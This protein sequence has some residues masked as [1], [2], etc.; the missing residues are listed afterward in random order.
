MKRA[1]LF[2][3]GGFGVALLASPLVMLAV[4]RT[5]PGDDPTLQAPTFHFWVVSMTSLA[6]AVAG[7]LII[8]SA[9]TLRETRLLFLALAFVSIAGV[10]AVHGLMTPG[11]IADHSYSSVPVSAWAS[12]FVGAV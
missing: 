6:A 3:L 9:R 11:F 4:L 10:F 8:A 5:H 2:V 1:M 7:G 12:V